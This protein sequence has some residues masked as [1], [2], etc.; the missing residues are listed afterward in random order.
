[1]QNTRF[2]GRFN[3]GCSVSRT[4]KRRG[5]VFD[6]VRR[7]SRVPLT[8]RALNKVGHAGVMRLSWLRD[9]PLAP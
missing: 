2:C 5:A 7:R 3:V 9:S 1:M 6:S 4:R 8:A